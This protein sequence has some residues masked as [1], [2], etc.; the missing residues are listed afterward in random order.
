MIKFKTE[1]RLQF[2]TFNSIHL[3]IN[4]GDYG[5]LETDNILHAIEGE[6][7]YCGLATEGKLIVTEKQID[8]LLEVV[9]LVIY[10]ISQNIISFKP[11]PVTELKKLKIQAKFLLTENFDDDLED[12][13]MIFQ[14]I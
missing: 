11:T 14:L 13:I 10:R 2:L 4:P 12:D 5:I 6:F 8:K 7:F 9:N 3:D 1:G